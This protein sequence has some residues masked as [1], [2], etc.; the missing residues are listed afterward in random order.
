MAIV[1]EGSYKR[2]KQTLHSLVPEHIDPLPEFELEGHNDGMTPLDLARASE[3]L[4]KVIW[5]QPDLTQSQCLVV[6]TLSIMFLDA[7]VNTCITLIGAQCVLLHVALR[8][9]VRLSD[10][11]AR[12]VNPEGMPFFNELLRVARALLSSVSWEKTMAKHQLPCDLSDFVDG[13]LFCETWIMVHSLG[14]KQAMLPSLESPYNSLASLVDNLCGTTM[15]C[16]STGRSKANHGPAVLSKSTI[17]FSDSAATVLPFDNPVFDTHLQPVQL[18]V[19]KSN[20]LSPEVVISRNFEEQSHWHSS[21]PLDQKA[22]MTL[23]PEILKRMLRKNQFFMAEMMDYAASLSGSTGWLK[24]ET[25]IVESSQKKARS[26][27][28]TGAKYI[29]SS[30]QK[31]SQSKSGAPSIREMAAATIQ[32]KQEKEAQGYRLRWK[33]KQKEFRQITDLPDRFLKVNDYLFSLSKAT[34][35]TL[36]AEVLT[37]ALDTLVR[38]IFAKYKS[39]QGKKHVPIATR[40]WELITR[41]TKLRQGVSAEIVTHVGA[42]C[43]LLKLPVPQL[44]AQNHDPLSFSMFE[45]PNPCPDVGIEMSPVEFQLLHGGPFMER[46]M[47][48][49]PDA[50]TPEFEPDHWQRDVLDQIDAKKS[51]LVVA[52]TSAGKTFIS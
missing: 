18:S 6:V 46:G 35:Q 14:L 5:W 48:S 4:E 47:D 50:R 3:L 34:R 43:K 36:A 45:T 38:L 37:Y 49:L 52:P 15:E 41:L 42:V 32:H 10:R 8:Q 19:D 11:G 25:I 9:N 13:R 20:N 24:P 26:N 23:P 51:V 44:E 21:K 22:K 31:K 29:P 28:R 30:Q 1:I 33:E 16:T 2:T 17:E 40:I 39:T 27:K 12:N 7:D